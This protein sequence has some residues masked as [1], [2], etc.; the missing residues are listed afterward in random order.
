MKFIAF[1]AAWVTLVIL[2][3]KLNGQELIPM[4][5]Q[6]WWGYVDEKGKFVI[7]PKFLEA[8]NFSDGLAA[9][10]LDFYWG[11]IDKKGTLIIPFR[12]QV[13]KSFS[14]GMA[15]VKLYGK[16]GYI[17]KTDKVIIPINFQEVGNFS[18]GLAAVKLNGKWGFIDKT[19]KV[20]IPIN[21]QEVGNFS[22]GLAAVKL[23]GKWGYVDKTGNGVIPIN[24]QEVGSFKYGMAP[25]RLN[26]KWGFAD[27]TGKIVIPCNYKQVENYSEDLVLVS[28]G[29]FWGAVDINGAE[30]V[31]HIYNDSRSVRDVIAKQGVRKPIEKNLFTQNQT[32]P[33]TVQTDKQKTATPEITVAKSDIAVNIPV[34]AVKNEYTFAVI[35]ANENYQRESQVVFAKNDGEVFYQYC[36]KTLGLPEKNIRFIQNA[37]LNNIRAE[38][39]W[40]SRV[41]DAYDGEAN[42]IFY[43]AGHGI[44][45][46]NSGNAYLLPVDG[47]G[48]DLITA[49]KIEDL[50]SKLG[51]LS[52][53]SVTIFLDAC[54]SGAQRSGGMMVSSR[55]VAIK[56]KENVPTG[57]TVVFSAAHGDETA[58]P[59]HEKEHGMFTYFLLKKLQE[60]K[61]DVTFGELGDYIITNVKRQSVVVNNK[62]QT[63]T[64][65]PSTSI[66]EN[67]RK[68]KLK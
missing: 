35:I 14:E 67:W 22:D 63:P 13:A 3:V 10:V 20:I 27:K 42:I 25:V 1:L 16:W 2:S 34:T 51:T 26:K 57:N 5:K 21:F 60:T 66:G 50:Y 44:P 12:Y 43:Y 41:A 11:F 37:T 36:I 64:I 24:F 6:G 49:Y 54:F 55:G 56:P 19:G 32:Q 65:V 4:K 61:G 29:K 9:V 39:N 17:D 62:S 40:I 15:A 30:F 8:Q 46:E 53:R 58:Y 45:D 47:Y 48:S 7:P 31:P 59:F 33:Q 38:I 18:D 68:L 28:N 23:D 52:A